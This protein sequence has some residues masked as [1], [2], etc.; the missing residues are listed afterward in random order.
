MSSFGGVVSEARSSYKHKDPNEYGF[1]IACDDRAI[2]NCVNSM[3]LNNGVLGLSDTD[4]KMHY[5]IDGRRG[6]E[7]AAMQVA[8]HVR[9]FQEKDTG[10]QEVDHAYVYFAID[11]V[12]KKNGFDPTLVGL[13]ILRYLLFKL[14]EE[15][16]LLRSVSKLLY[17]KAYQVF[18]MTPSQVE[19]NIRYAM[20]KR[21][22]QGEK[23]RVVTVIRHLL[24]A[25]ME[26]MFRSYGRAGQAK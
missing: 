9:F 4:G 20:K 6:K 11:T 23:A 26:E 15:P 13:Q 14:V 22:K 5:L 16:V 3:L 8:Q 10:P 19:R 21:T 2:L 1:Y 25:S 18:R 7:Y 12:L 17:P 24:D